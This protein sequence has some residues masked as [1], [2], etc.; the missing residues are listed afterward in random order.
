MI[1]FRYH[2]VSIAAIFLALAVGVALGS[3]PLDN[4]KNIVGDNTAAATTTAQGDL[5]SFE[6]AYASKTA[7]GLIRGKLKGQTVT[8]FTV[9][10]ARPDEVRGLKSAMVSG[11]AVVTGQVALT[12]KLLDSANRQFA[13]GVAQQSAKGASGVASSGDSYALIGSALG[14]AYLGDVPGKLDPAGTTIAAAFAEG[15]LVSSSEKPTQ[16]ASLALIVVGPTS[17]G[18]DRGQ[19]NIVAQL[20]GAFDSQAKGVV[21]AGPSQ[22][23]DDGGYLQALRASDAATKVSSIDVSDSS[24]GRLLT[25]L[26]AAREIT[27]NAGAFGTS[28]SADGAFPR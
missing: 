5:A 15:K 3:G 16:R 24:A 2:L 27:D 26:V 13:E 25:V 7:P 9:P 18:G 14:R 23:S 1:N 20:A 8:I 28:R 12:S 10:G 11:G 6:S 19:A 21:V 22:S 17:A 4:A